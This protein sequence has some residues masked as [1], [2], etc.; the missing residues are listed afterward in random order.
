MQVPVD[1]QF[2][3]DLAAF[4]LRFTCDDCLYFQ[5]DD[6]ACAHEWPTK[7]HRLPVIETVVFCKEFELL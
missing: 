1:G 2:F 6:Q 7:E 4:S 3:H 5:P